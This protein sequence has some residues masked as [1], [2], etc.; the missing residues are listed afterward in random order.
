[1]GQHKIIVKLISHSDG[2]YN[3]IATFTADIAWMLDESDNVI[4]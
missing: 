1:M 4:H 3:I 2:P